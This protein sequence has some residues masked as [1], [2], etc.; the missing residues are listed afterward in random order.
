M[1][2]FRSS[3]QR[4]K[5]LLAA[6]TLPD[7]EW[8][9][10]YLALKIR[11]GMMDVTPDLLPDQDTG[12]QM[13]LQSGCE[14]L[15]SALVT[16]AG[17]A[18]KYLGNGLSFLSDRIFTALRNNAET[19]FLSYS[20][21][22]TNYKIRVWKNARD[23]DGEK[24]DA[25]MLKVVP[26]DQL[27]KRVTAVEAV[28]KALSSVKAIYDSTIPTT[29]SWMTPECD[30]AIA[31]ME[32]IGF[33]AR[34]Y[35]FLSNVSKVYG[36]ARKKQPLFMHK[37]TPKGILGLI[38]RCDKLTQYADPK[39]IQDFQDKYESCLEAL[40]KFELTTEMDDLSEKEKASREHELKIKAARL[41]WIAHFAKAAYTVTTDIFAD[42]GKLA[43]ATERCIA[44]PDNG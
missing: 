38:D 35:E 4:A 19:T 13:G 9:R 11:L 37:Y 1:T 5:A 24:F 29:N 21:I 14:D 22:L 16:F 3:S 15:N 34:H 30:R 17:M 10:I 27:C 36:D 42:I 6:K 28:H 32:R 20:Q 40:D 43:T 33:Q 25:Y 41:W 12:Y 2:K 26:Y 23:L 39:Y 8:N 18:V 44:T 7:D 31:A